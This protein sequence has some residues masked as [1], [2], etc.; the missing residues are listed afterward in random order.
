MYRVAYPPSPTLRDYKIQ[1]SEFETN[2]LLM[3]PGYGRPREVILKSLN[4]V[5]TASVV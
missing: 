5:R 3:G 1:V 4:T 2:E